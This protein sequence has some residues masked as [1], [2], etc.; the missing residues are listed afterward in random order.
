[1]RLDHDGRRIEMH[2]AEGVT[3]SCDEGSAGESA[4]RGS[5]DEAVGAE[6]HVEERK[7]ARRT[8]FDAPLP[9]HL[10][11]ERERRLAGRP[12]K[13]A[14][15]HLFGTP[16]LLDAGEVLLRERLLDPLQYAA[17]IDG[18]HPALGTLRAAR[19]FE[20]NAAVVVGPRQRACRGRPH[21]LHA[22]RARLQ[23]CQMLAVAAGKADDGCQCRQRARERVHVAI[24]AQRSALKSAFLAKEPPWSTSPLEAASF[25]HDNPN[26][27]FIDCRSEM[28]F[29]FVGHPAGAL[30][31]SWNDGPDWEVNPHFAGE[32]KSSRGPR[33]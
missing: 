23:R 25:L 2:G 18:Q 6:M 33:P 14:V 29:A 8:R 20:R 4:S 15:A 3:P 19:V 31:V 27:L 24:I 32:V 10:R 1:M 21:L 7:I 30:H 13:Q 28:E 5:R 16:A 26:A 11:L 9:D 12:A 17:H 22:R